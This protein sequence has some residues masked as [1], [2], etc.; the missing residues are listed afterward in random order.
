[1]DISNIC[2]ATLGPWCLWDSVGFIFMIV[3]CPNQ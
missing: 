1:M 3:I 2:V